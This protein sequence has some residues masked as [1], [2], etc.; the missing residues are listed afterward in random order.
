M[1]TLRATAMVKGADS[2][3]AT[4]AAGQEDALQ[5]LAGDRTAYFWSRSAALRAMPSASDAKSLRS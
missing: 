2:L 3:A 1:L 5:T 4:C